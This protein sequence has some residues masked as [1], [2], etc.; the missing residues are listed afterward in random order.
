ML[1]KRKRKY[2]DKVIEIIFKSKRVEKACTDFKKAKKDYGETTAIKLFALI[3]L[4]MNAVNLT[5]VK[6]VKSY[7]LHKLDGNMQGKYSIY[8]GKKSG[9]RLIIIPLN[10]EYEQWEE[11]NFDIICLN[12]QIVEIQEV[13]KYYE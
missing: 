12:T 9:I 11:K 7:Y 1:L 4:M 13:S 6:A 8:I 3:N 5:D 10:R 2:K